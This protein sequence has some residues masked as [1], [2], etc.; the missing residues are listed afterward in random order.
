MDEKLVTAKQK[1]PFHTMGLSP[2]LVAGTSQG[3]VP[4][5][6]L[7]FSVLLKGAVMFVFC[8]ETCDVM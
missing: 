6:V 8:M 3:L 1:W 5:C 2:Q 4:S 7:T